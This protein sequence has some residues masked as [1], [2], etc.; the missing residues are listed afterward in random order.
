MNH[1]TSSKYPPSLKGSLLPK[2]IWDNNVLYLPKPLI[3]AHHKQLLAG[4]W[5]D[6]YHSDDKS[7]IVGGASKLEAEIHFIKRFLNSAARAQFVC[8]DP[9]DSQAD[10]RDMILDQLASGH[11]FI[12]DL[13]AGNG[14]GTLA[15]LSLLC[16]LRE[17]E[18][19]PKLPLNV[20][21]YGID[22]SPDALLFYQNTLIDLDEWLEG[23][24][25]NVQLDSWP[26][27]LKV[28]SDFSEILDNF[29]NDAKSCQVNRFLC[30]LSAI[31]GLGKDGLEEIHKSLETAAIRL[32]HKNHESSWLWIEPSTTNN[33]FS[34]I[35]NSIK[36]ALQRIP[37]IFSKKND[38]F[39]IR[40]NASLIPDPEIRTFH[41]QDPHQSKIIKSKVMVFGFK[42]A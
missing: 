13:A 35:L 42:N 19:I 4:N 34:K 5:M 17:K 20:K 37:Y 28:V 22:F 32:S 1:L 3:D 41:W 11:I 7:D 14:A 29:F 24:G 10:I 27:D 39:E 21:I 2:S 30:V 8:A 23:K 9:I 26:C 31:S 36:F 25:I 40:S 6:I 33:W 18:C 15:I 12:L 16:E 38:S